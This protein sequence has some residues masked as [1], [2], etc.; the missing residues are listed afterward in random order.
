MEN[1]SLE[2]IQTF[3]SLKVEDFIKLFSQTKFVMNHDHLI[4]LSLRQTTLE[5]AIFEEM[6]NSKILFTKETLKITMGADFDCEKFSKEEIYN[7][8]ANQ[9]KDL[10]Y[11][12]LD[13]NL[14]EEIF[15]IHSF[16]DYQNGALNIKKG[17]DLSYELLEN[18]SL[19]E[20]IRIKY[21][22]NEKGELD[23]KLSEFVNSLA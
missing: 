19:K 12:I 3:G 9:N 6:Q 1:N 16:E 8:F 20:K 13:L 11:E 18:K 22:L 5:K 2:I 21:L 15:I 10:I 7:I 4:M 14:F 17:N 23:E